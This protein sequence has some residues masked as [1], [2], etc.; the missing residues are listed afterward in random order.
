MS[1]VELAMLFGVERDLILCPVLAGIMSE[2]NPR[3]TYQ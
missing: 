3:Q 1:S 2:N